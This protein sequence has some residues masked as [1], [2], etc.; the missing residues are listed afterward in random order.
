MDVHNP[1][2]TLRSSGSCLQHQVWPKQHPART[3]DR[4]Q[5]LGSMV[6]PGQ[7][8]SC[9]PILSLVLS[10]KPPYSSSPLAKPVVVYLKIWGKK[11]RLYTSAFSFLLSV[12]PS[13]TLNQCRP[14]L[15][16]LE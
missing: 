16:R 13:S 12:A 3:R 11:H 10:W 8:P 1:L 5:H 4:C 2:R 14:P 7:N 9:C 6:W 15:R